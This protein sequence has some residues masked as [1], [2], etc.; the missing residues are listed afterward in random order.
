MNDNGSRN[1]TGEDIE[2]VTV[3]IGEQMFG[4][5]IDRVHDVFIANSITQVPLS[6]PEIRGLLNLRG[7]VVTAICMRSRL[8]LA[9][10][11]GNTD[12]MAVGLEHN[13][14]SYGLLVDQVGEVLKLPSSS[15]EPNPVHLD[16]RWAKL[17]RGVHRLEN[18]LLIIFDV[19]AILDYEAVAKAA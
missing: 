11:D 10:R 3:L 15:L 6:P 18:K 1:M 16:P 17:S 7:R 12:D 14:E 2:Y 13:G 8:G 4:I 9:E 19:E 5:R